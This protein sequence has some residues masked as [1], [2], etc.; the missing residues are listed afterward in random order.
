MSLN[1]DDDDE[2]YMLLQR[3]YN[4]VQKAMMMNAY[5]P[6]TSA[7]SLFLKWRSGLPWIPRSTDG[8]KQ[9]RFL[10]GSFLLTR[11]GSMIKFLGS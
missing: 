6:W 7:S 11:N 4:I 5:M 8:F 1:K 2:K 3:A 10:C 9:W